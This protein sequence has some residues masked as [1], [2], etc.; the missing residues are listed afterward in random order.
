MELTFDFV[1]IGPSNFLVAIWA[2]WHSGILS[3]KGVG[4][5][6]EFK[7]LQAKIKLTLISLNQIY[8]MNL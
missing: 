4:E 1:R 3:L 2:I 8:T 5:K 7:V 6:E